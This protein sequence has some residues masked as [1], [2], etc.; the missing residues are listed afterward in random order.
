[1]KNTTVGVTERLSLFGRHAKHDWSFNP[2]TLRETGMA[3]RLPGSKDKR[4]DSA[5]IR[6]FVPA[7]HAP[8]Q[9]SFYER[10]NLTPKQKRAKAAGHTCIPA[11]LKQGSWAPMDNCRP[12]A[13][14]QGE[15]M[16]GRK[17]KMESVA[18]KQGRMVARLQADPT[19]A[20]APKQEIAF[21][22]PFDVEK[23]GE[24]VQIRAFADIC[25]AR[26]RRCVR[27]RMNM[28]G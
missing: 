12:V 25:A 17:V 15:Q 28:V 1:M 18:A 19:L 6:D 5:H 21:L 2:A 22:V 8:K 3:A 20:D 16:Q 10:N 13:K 23:R 27:G 26:G 14:Q 24:S 4:S 9:P 7:T 11:T